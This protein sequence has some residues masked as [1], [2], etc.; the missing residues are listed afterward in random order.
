MPFYVP[1]ATTMAQFS[2]CNAIFFLPGPFFFFWGYVYLIFKLE[3]K[4]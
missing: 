4:F 1:S 2:F 3:D